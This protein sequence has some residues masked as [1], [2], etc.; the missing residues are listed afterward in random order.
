MKAHIKPYLLLV[1]AAI[2]YGLGYPTEF[3]TSLLI[4][5]IIAT[6]LLFY[7]L[8][9]APNWKQRFLRFLFFNSVLNIFSFYWITHTLQEFGELPW[10]VA[11]LL[12]LLFAFIIGPHFW[13][14]LIIGDNPCHPNRGFKRPSKL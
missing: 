12:N 1:I 4:T 10:I 8:I 13:V 2:F 5:P 7:L 9:Q 3:S 14:L 6:T 11:F